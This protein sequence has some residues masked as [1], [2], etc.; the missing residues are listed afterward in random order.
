MTDLAHDEAPNAPVDFSVPAE[1][2]VGRGSRRQT[3]LRFRS[4]PTLA[5]A[6][7]HVMETPHGAGEVATI[8]A[9]EDRFTSRQIAELYNDERYPLARI[10]A[11]EPT[12]KAEPPAETH[13]KS[14]AVPGTRR[15]AARAAPEA[16]PVTAFRTEASSP[17]SGSTPA[18][19]F[20][21]G[22]RLRMKHGGNT[23][24]RPSAYC[25]VVFL[26]PY[27]GG[28]LLYR[29]KSEAESFERVVA[30]ADLALA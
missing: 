16:Q 3:G 7:R 13:M 11:A 28:Q 15:S 30:E 17:R 20:K 9:G 26:L 2:Y 14:I 19:R 24:A 4:F 21:V 27:E 1:L 6:I 29:V 5:E 10:R 12:P 22:A 23:L 8:E 18:H 25:R